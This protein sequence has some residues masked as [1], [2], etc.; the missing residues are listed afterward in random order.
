MLAVQST[1]ARR[2][3]TSLDMALDQLLASRWPP[4]AWQEVRDAAELPWRFEELART[5][6]GSWRAFTD[7][8]RHALA[9]GWFVP[10]ARADSLQLMVRFFDT[11]ARSCGAGIWARTTDGGW[12]LREALD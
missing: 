6:E 4:A 12:I 9:V 7:G 5:L 3:A 10:G 2:I 8:T 1:G 11:A